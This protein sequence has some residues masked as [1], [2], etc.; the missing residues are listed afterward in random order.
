M[1]LAAGRQP[2]VFFLRKGLQL[3]YRALAFLLECAVAAPAG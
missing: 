3:L 1:R 2:A